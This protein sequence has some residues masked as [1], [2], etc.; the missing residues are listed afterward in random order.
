MELLDQADSALVIAVAQRPVQGLG[1][2]VE[3]IDGGLFTTRHDALAADWLGAARNGY[4][5]QCGGTGATRPH[6]KTTAAAPSL[7]GHHDVV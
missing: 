4:R 7:A 2:F 3:V 5:W 1:A 6:R